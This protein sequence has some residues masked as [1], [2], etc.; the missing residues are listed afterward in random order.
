MTAN[1]LT[2]S[3]LAKHLR[4]RN[5]RMCSVESCTGGWVAQQ[6]TDVAGSS[7]WFE[8][9]WVTYSNNAKMRDVGVSPQ[10]LNEF[11]AVSHQTAAEMARGGALAAGV[12]VAVSITGVAGPGG[13]SL[14]K[15]VG[16]VCFGWLID[17]EVNTQVQQFDGDRKQV[18]EQSVTHI[19]ETLLADLQ[20]S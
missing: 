12:A 2:I 3:E 9:G 10:T 5:W 8:C 16:T 11:G 15:P 13:G 17:G 6:L 18:R 4:R 7:D 14:E 19:L 1:D 20:Q